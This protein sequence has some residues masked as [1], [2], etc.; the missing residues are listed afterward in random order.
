[1]NNKKKTPKE[2]LKREKE[3]LEKKSDILVDSISNTLEYTH[4]N[5]GVIVRQTA[6]EA[7]SPALPSFAQRIFGGGLAGIAADL[8]PFFLKGKKGVI[9]AFILK[10]LKRFF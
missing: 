9:A 5:L 7:V 10:K 8:L 4:N 2:I 1:M 3:L 6:L